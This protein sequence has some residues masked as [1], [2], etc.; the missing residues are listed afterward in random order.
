MTFR[1]STILA[2]LA[3]ALALGG[4]ASSE[5]DPAG[6]AETTDQSS[7][8][9]DT[10]K[11]DD[12]PDASASPTDDSPKAT[13][14]SESAD[15]SEIEIPQPS[16][17]VMWGKSVSKLKDGKSKAKI[18]PGL[19]AQADTAKG[20]VIAVPRDDTMEALYGKYDNSV[21]VL[22]DGLPALIVEQPETPGSEFDWKWDVHQHESH[23]LLEAVS[24]TSETGTKPATVEALLAETAV[25]SAE[26]VTE[27]EG[28]RL[29][30]TPGK[31]ARTGS[32]NV[33]QY[34][35]DTVVQSVPDVIDWDLNS[36]E[37]QFTCHAI[38]AL[39]KDTWNL[40]T[41]R[42][43]VGLLEFMAAKCNP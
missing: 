24:T 14:Q 8:S 15:S 12:T 3:L 39:D 40:E 11:A 34:G 22:K 35:W 36:L 23:Y 25:E 38:G 10:A 6:P 29:I 2:A 42:E 18:G 32:M 41:W 33:Q 30:I 19:I 7:T 9:A 20:L 16:A 1:F 4:C 43:D 37:N 27:P 31:W 5:T 28:K 21:I 13:E 17:T 26:W